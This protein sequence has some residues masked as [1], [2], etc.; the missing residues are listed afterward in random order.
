M[1]RCVGIALVALLTIQQPAK[2]IVLG[3]TPGAPFNARLPD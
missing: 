1:T 3:R 2:C